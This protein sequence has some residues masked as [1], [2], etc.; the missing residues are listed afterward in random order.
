M[1]SKISVSE[2]LNLFYT[3]KDSTAL[4]HAN[5]HSEED[6]TPPPVDNHEFYEADPDSGIIE[7]HIQKRF[8]AI[9]GTLII[10]EYIF[11]LLICYLYWLKKHFRVCMMPKQESKPRL[12]SV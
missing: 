8:V 2:F 1:I 9:R 5:N 6:Q 7:F 4:Q 10:M 3:Q 11:Q 12:Q